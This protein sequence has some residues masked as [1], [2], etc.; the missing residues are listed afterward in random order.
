MG[1]R[2]RFVLYLP[3]RRCHG[4]PPL[5]LNLHG[6]TSYPEEQMAISGIIPVA[7]R[8]GFAVLAP[9]G[10][11]RQWNV[12][13]DPAG[14]DDV[15]FIQDALDAAAR[16]AAIDCNRLYATGFSAGGRMLSLLASKLPV[17]VIAPIGG[18]RKPAA[19]PPERSVRVVA[20]HGLDDPINPYGGAGPSYWQTGVEDALHGWAEHNGLRGAPR[21][22]RLAPSVTRIGFDANDRSVLL[23]RVDGLG[24]QWPGSTIDIGT[25]FGAHA[26]TPSATSCMFEHFISDR[27]P[28]HEVNRR[29]VEAQ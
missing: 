3:T 26:T 20:F 25:L 18:L 21:I 27:G 16:S 6:S 9:E 22:D 29:M 12:P 7:D 14:P 1:R 4:S 28:I 19:P 23:Y 13:F 11:E 24:H 2:R 17:A 8:Y 5:I 10:F 15:G